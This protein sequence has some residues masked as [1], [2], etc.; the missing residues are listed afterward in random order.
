[1]NA[2]EPVDGEGASLAIWRTAPSLEGRRTA[3][4]G[5]FACETAEAGAALLRAT[6]ARLKAEGFGAV[7]GPMDG[8]TWSSHRLVVWSNGRTPFPLEPQNP[9][10]YPA[11]FETAGFDVVSHY[12]SSEGGVDN[13][14]PAPGPLEDGL[15]Y[16]AL[17]PADAE[18]V[19]RRVHALSLEAFADN[20]FYVPSAEQPFVAG[21]L[22]VLPFVDPELVLLPADS[23]GRLHGFLFAY[24]DFGSPGALVLQTYA[25]RR[26][27]LGSHMA[28]ELYARA[29]AKGF[30]RIVHALMHESNLSARHS[31]AVGGEVF[32]R[33]ALWGLKL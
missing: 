25:S 32:R 19:L 29:R 23:E 30:T 5:R 14:R 3:A 22:K 11:A 26:K 12:L 8:D 21:Y 2:V 1:M 17:D 27:G 20:A 24:P 13:G 4:L 33:Y 10:W 15:R 16:L 7:L 9:D 28:A 31:E 6:A 18:P